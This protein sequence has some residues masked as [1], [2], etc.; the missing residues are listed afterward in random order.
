MHAWMLHRAFVIKD[1]IGAE[2]NIGIEELTVER[3]ES[4]GFGEGRDLFT[5]L[6][7]REDVL[8]V[9]REAAE[10]GLDV[11]LELLLCGAGFQVA[12]EDGRGIVG[13]LAGGRAESGV[14][15]GDAF[16]VEGGFHFHY[17]GLDRIEAAQEGHG[18]D[19]ITVFGA[20]V[21][22]AKDIVGDVP[23]EVGEPDELG[24]VH[25]VGY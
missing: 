17:G 6:E 10:A 24:M 13:L 8:A 20:G 21:N 5:E 14:L 9:G 11:V 18:Q 1:G 15:I 16:F 7:V 3:A 23:D 22:V 25:E 12:Q 19:D 2:I 4:I